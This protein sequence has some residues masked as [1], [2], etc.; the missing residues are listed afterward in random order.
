M[1]HA[2]KCSFTPVPRTWR[3]FD[4]FIWLI[5]RGAI[6]IGFRD[7]PRILMSFAIE[8]HYSLLMRQL[9]PLY[10]IP[11]HFFFL[12][13]HYNT[14]LYIWILTRRSFEELGTGILIFL[15]IIRANWY[16]YDWARDILAH[17]AFMSTLSPWL[18]CTPSRN[19]YKA[20]DYILLVK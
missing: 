5:R 16:R 7:E 13:I 15:F 1:F 9:P 2:Q 11:P 20:T 3:H 18:S 10:K 4:G 6:V 8:Y 19:K 17:W 14:R 12:D